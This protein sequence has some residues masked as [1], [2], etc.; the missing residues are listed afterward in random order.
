[1]QFNPTTNALTYNLS[2]TSYTFSNV[3]DQALQVNL[4]QGGLANAS[5][6]GG[7]LSLVPKITASLTLGINLTPLGQGF[8]LTP[9]TCLST[10]NGGAGVRINGTSPDLQITLTNGTS[11]QVSL[12][13]AQ[14]VQNVITDIETATD[15]AVSVTI[16][17]TSQQALDVTQMS[18]AMV[19]SSSGSFTVAAINGSYAA[20]DLGIAGS[21]NPADLQMVGSSRGAPPSSRGNLCPATPC[22]TTFSLKAR[23][24]RLA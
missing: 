3:L 17:P 2:F 14:T 5:L 22:R 21:Y 9:A 8:V 24:S 7:Q 6:G 18:P 4:D 16:D 20:A 15:G 23:R 13:G 12:S 1:M 10:L 11:F 19:T